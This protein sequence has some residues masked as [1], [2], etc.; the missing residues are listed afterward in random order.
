VENY[1]GVLKKT[2]KKAQ[3]NKGKHKKYK[4]QQVI[5]NISLLFLKNIYI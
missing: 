4:K 2:C 5:K 1:E 3:T